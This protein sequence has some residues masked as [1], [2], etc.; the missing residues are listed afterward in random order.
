[1]GD[2]SILDEIKRKSPLIHCITNPISITQCANTVLALGAKPI[3]AE[4]P[5]EVK[6]ITATADALLINLG[7][8]SDVRMKSMEISF[9]EAL[10]KG[11]PVVIDAVGVACSRLRLD[12]INKL[13]EQRKILCGE[14][15]KC[16]LLIKGNYSEIRALADDNY[17]S[18]GVDADSSLEE[19]NIKRLAKKLADKYQC[20]VL[21]SGSTDIVS[22]ENRTFYIKNGTV[23]M[24][25]I[26]GTGC[27]LGTICATFAAAKGYSDA[28]TI[29]DACAYFGIA[30]ELAKES[31]MK[32]ENRVGS[33][34]FFVKLMD[35]LSLLN[36][37][38]FD[39]RRM[40]I[41]I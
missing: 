31:L 1:M 11:I 3:M 28:E 37:E 25:K 36:E 4:H 41:R 20:V 33:G 17:R 23:E 39:G 9:A 30:G 27:M 34:S 35:E 5:L 14:A 2:I 18:R 26:T 15:E 10:S 19:G 38:S 16:T 22:D 12:Y 8:I 24:G 7:N 21:G 29:S 40:I 13:L 32:L 6:E